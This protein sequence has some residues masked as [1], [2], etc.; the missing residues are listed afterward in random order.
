MLF[1]IASSSLLAIGLGNLN[2]KS[3]SIEATLPVVKTVDLVENE[4]NYITPKSNE[5]YF[6]TK[7]K[8]ER[9]EMAHKEG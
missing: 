9:L 5:D 8:S 2:R 7:S 1:I 4:E 3:E 6:K